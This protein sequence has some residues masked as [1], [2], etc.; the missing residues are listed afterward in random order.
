MTENE[1]EAFEE[2]AAICEY[3]GQV[4]R[5]AAEELAWQEYQLKRL[6]D[7]GGQA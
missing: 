7:V 4:E 1:K 6:N 2:R 3:D 5:E